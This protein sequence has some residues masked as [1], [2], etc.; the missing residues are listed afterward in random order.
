MIF[1]C[2]HA[3]CDRYLGCWSRRAAVI[4]GPFRSCPIACGVTKAVHCYGSQTDVVNLGSLLHDLGHLLAAGIALGSLLGEA[5]MLVEICC[6]FEANGH[7]VLL[8][9]VQNLEGMTKGASLIENACVIAKPAEDLLGGRQVDA[10]E[11][12]SQALHLQG[13]VGT[14]LLVLQSMEMIDGPILDLFQVRVFFGFGCKAT[15]TIHDKTI[16][17]LVLWQ[18]REQRAVH[19]GIVFW[20]AHAGHSKNPLVSR[21]HHHEPSMPIRL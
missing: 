7:V 12:L 6:L 18:D 10:L 14:G 9:K 4:L 15:D 17:V 3:K 11:S 8:D 5:L 20:L 21:I 16:Q 2:L 1:E 19:N 13:V